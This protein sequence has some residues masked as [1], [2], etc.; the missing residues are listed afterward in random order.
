MNT[1]SG[2]KLTKK[3][4]ARLP[5]LSPSAVASSQPPPPHLLSPDNRSVRSVSSTGSKRPGLAG[6]I[7]KQLAIDIET[8]IPGG[9]SAFLAKTPKTQLL[10]PLLDRRAALDHEAGRQPLYGERGDKIRATVGKYVDRW[11]NLPRD[12][13]REKILDKWNIAPAKKITKKQLESAKKEPSR[14]TAAKTP[15]KA[16]V[17]L[18]F[19]S[20]RDKDDSSISSGEEDSGGFHIKEIRTVAKVTS[21]TLQFPAEKTSEVPALIIDSDIN[22][23]TMSV[24]G[25]TGSLYSNS[26]AVKLPQPQP[27]KSNPSLPAADPRQQPL[28]GGGDNDDGGSDSSSSKNYFDY[29]FEFTSEQDE[30]A[31]WID[32]KIEELNQDHGDASSFL[33]SRRLQSRLRQEDEAARER[34]ASSGEDL[35]Q[36]VEVENA[37]MSDEGGHNKRSASSLVAASEKEGLLKWNRVDNDNNGGV[38]GGSGDY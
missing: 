10:A 28:P 9:I 15:Q 22:T 36:H 7:Q 33:S 5:P 8:Q 29:D 24:A 18:D 3:G 16:A 37:I 12:E 19:E 2:R 34:Q 17:S 14:A 11:K 4:E 35:A 27:P 6:H 21:G 32:Q 30:D 31:A 25:A 23:E 20:Y 26:S 38:G 13:Y 1:R